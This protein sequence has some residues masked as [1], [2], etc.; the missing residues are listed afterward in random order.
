MFYICIDC[1][2]P[3]LSIHFWY[4]LQENLWGP[5]PAVNPA[6]KQRNN[7]GSEQ[8]NAAN[9]DKK[10]KA[11]PKKTK[12]MDATALLG[13][14]VGASSTRLNIGEIEKAE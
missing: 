7:P 2:L 10:K 12:K 9:A 5:A 14:S 11:G 3:C 1:C 6:S 13:F 4:L 8:S